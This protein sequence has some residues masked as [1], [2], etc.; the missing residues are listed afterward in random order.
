M[1]RNKKK[2]VQV[3]YAGNHHCCNLNVFKVVV[4]IISSSSS[5]N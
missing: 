2:L 3:N 4:I 1:I 5:S